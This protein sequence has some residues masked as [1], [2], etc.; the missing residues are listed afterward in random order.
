MIRTRHRL[1]FIDV[2]I[3]LALAFSISGLLLFSLMS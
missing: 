3:G 2:M 1:I